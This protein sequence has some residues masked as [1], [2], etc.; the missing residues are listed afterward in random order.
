[1]LWYL[2]SQ[3]FKGIEFRRWSVLAEQ[4]EVVGKMERYLSAILRNPLIGNLKTIRIDGFSSVD[5]LLPVFEKCTFL[6]EIQINCNDEIISGP[7]G[8]RCI[9]L[10]SQLRTLKVFSL[11][12]NHLVFASILA[13]FQSMSLRH[14]AYWTTAEDSDENDLVNVIEKLS[15][16]QVQHL[17]ITGLKQDQPLNLTQWLLALR[18]NAYIN[19]L[20]LKWATVDAIDPSL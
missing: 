17:E 14:I 15:S 18:E 2:S 4:R 1:V 12:S 8:K 10:L 5:Y 9:E 13:A 3:D 6:E 16:I 20:T 11:T 7:T 19:Q